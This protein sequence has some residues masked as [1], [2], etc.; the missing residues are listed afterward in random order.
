MKSTIEF[1]PRCGVKRIVLLM[2]SLYITNATFSQSD[3]IPFINGKITYTETVNIDSVNGNELYNRAKNWIIHNFKAPKNVIQ[4]DDKEQGI[5]L[6][7]GTFH[8]NFGGKTPAIS[9]T[10]EIEVK[11]NKY[12]Y[13]MTDFHYLDDNGDFDAENYPKMW[14][15]KNGFYKR[16]SEK[17]KE[18]LYSLKKAMLEKIDNNW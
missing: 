14:L 8:I 1:C 13:T 6:C 7:N 3:S 18:I 9:N 15:S 10:L 16:L 2:L 5:I 11:D 4:V 17:T 12:R